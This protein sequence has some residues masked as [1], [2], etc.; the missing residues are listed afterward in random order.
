MGFFFWICTSRIPLLLRLLLHIPSPPPCHTE[1]LSHTS[2]SQTIFVTH[3]LSHTSLSVTIFHTESLSHTIFH[4]HLFVTH[5]FVTD[6]LCHTPSFTH[7]FVSHH[8]SHRIFVTHHLSHTPLCHTHLCHR[9]SFTPVTR[10]R[11]TYD[12]FVSRGRPGTWRHP[13]SFC[14]AG[15]VLITYHVCPNKHMYREEGVKM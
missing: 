9:P 3:H 11:G 8:L 1:S 15:V 10:R 13:P 14:V 7:I 4:T 5:I 12:S 6:H 2:L